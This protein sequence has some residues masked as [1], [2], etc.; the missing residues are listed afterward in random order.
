MSESTIMIATN[1]NDVFLPTTCW[2]LYLESADAF[3]KRVNYEIVISI[4]VQSYLLDINKNSF[5]KESSK[6]L[7]KLPLVTFII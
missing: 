7:Q 4:N 3:K 5:M 2:T 6:Y 1:L